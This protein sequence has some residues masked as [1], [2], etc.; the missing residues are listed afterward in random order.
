MKGADGGVDMSP[1]PGCSSEAE[2]QWPGGSTGRKHEVL[3]SLAGKKQLQP[4]RWLQGKRC[5]RR[6]GVGPMVAGSAFRATVEAL[7]RVS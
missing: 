4:W 5:T 7:P 1:I 3:Q 6:R 2:E